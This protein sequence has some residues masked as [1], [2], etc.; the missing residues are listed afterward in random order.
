MFAYGSLLNQASRERTT[1]AASQTSTTLEAR[2]AAAADITELST[3]A[4]KLDLLP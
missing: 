1:T 3:F 2:I 4:P